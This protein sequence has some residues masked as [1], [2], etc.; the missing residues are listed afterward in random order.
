MAGVIIL[1]EQIVTH[2]TCVSYMLKQVLGIGNPSAPSR[3]W[4]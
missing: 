2:F 4:V 1:D 3:N